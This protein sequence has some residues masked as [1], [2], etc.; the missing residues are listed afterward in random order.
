[1]QLTPRNVQNYAEEHTTPPSNVLYKLYRHTHLTNLRPQMLPGNLQGQLIH[2]VSCMIRPQYI[3]EIGTFTGYSAICW[4]QGLAPNGMLHTIEI[5]PELEQDCRHFFELANLQHQI[6]LHIGDATQIIPTLTHSWD[7]VYIDADKT[8]Y[9]N[10]YD[11][12]LPQLR[13]GGFIIAD[14]VLWDGKVPDPQYN[15]ADTVALRQF[16]DKVHNDPRV[17]N[18]LLPVRDG[19]MVIQKI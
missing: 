3:L 2:L 11:L 10:Y 17:H 5:N 6:H 9:A 13:S 7:V 12:V 8:N 19:W 1:M 16:N 4:A 14:N 15:D 18:V